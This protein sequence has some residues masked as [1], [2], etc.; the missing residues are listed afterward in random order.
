MHLQAGQILADKYRIVR[1]LGHGGMGAVYEGENVRIR[2]R[3]AIKTLHAQVSDRPDVL[4]RFEREAQAAGRIGSEHIVEVLD[5][6]DLPDGARFMVMEFLD[7]VTLGDRIVKQGRIQPRD[8]V[9]ILA[10]LLDGLTA[11]HAAGIIHRDLKPANVFLVAGR[12]GADFVKI[13][14]FGVSKFSV[15]ASEEMSM[16]RT[17]AVVGT[18]YYMSPEQAKGA[19]S[20]D[21]RSDLYSVGVILYEAVTGQVPFNAQTFNELIFKIALE[22]PPPPEQFAPNVDPGFSGIMRRAMA[23]EPNDRFQTAAEM[24]EALLAWAREYDAYGGMIPHRGSSPQLAAGITAALAPGAAGGAP[25]GQSQRTQLLPMVGPDKPGAGQQRP[26]VLTQPMP[27]MVAGVGQTAVLAQPPPNQPIMPTA[28]IPRVGSSPMIPLGLPPP[29]GAPSAQ[30]APGL[31]APHG[32]EEPT[33]LPPRNASGRVGLMLG[34]AAALAA[35]GVG[36]WLLYART[37]VAAATPAP[38]AAADDDDETGDASADETAAP[39]ASD[40]AGSAEPPASASPEASSSA[41]PT[42]ESAAPLSN[43][44]TPPATTRPWTPPT[45]ATASQPVRTSAPA[46]AAPTASTK[47]P[48]PPSTGTG[49]RPIGSDL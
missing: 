10:A 32:M 34:L 4:E 28:Q 20:I 18:P 3:V 5:L 8:L 37:R 23:R 1:L 13:L 30:L 9:P 7:G 17:G 16:T 39:S 12:G 27:Q 19:R 2:R 24:K 22:S 31:S 38:T 40:A 46:T 43:V 26:Q 33:Y 48:L 6:G 11:A 29:A 47:P 36:G 15:L 45:A 42:G 41:P 49:K 35:A 44:S 14:D 21:A 25:G